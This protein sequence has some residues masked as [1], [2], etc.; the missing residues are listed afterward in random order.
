[1][2]TKSLLIKQNTPFSFLLHLKLFFLKTWKVNVSV[3]KALLVSS[4]SFN[5]LCAINNIDVTVN[6]KSWQ[7]DFS[8]CM[9][10]VQKSDSTQF[11]IERRREKQSINPIVLVECRYHWY[12]DRFVQLKPGL[13]IQLSVRIVDQN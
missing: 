2:T 11:N 10:E 9:F 13:K 8:L 4:C 5:M 12:L 7:K 1:M 3:S 6:T